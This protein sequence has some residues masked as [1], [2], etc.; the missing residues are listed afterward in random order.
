M[1]HYGWIFAVLPSYIKN[2]KMYVVTWYDWRWAIA[3]LPQSSLY[4][5]M[6]FPSTRLC[7][8]N[9]PGKWKCYCYNESS[10]KLASI[11]ASSAMTQIA[12]MQRAQICS[13]LI[14]NITLTTKSFLSTKPSLIWV[15]R[16][17]SVGG[18]N[19]ESQL[20]AC[21]YQ[22][23]S[24][25]YTPE[26]RLRSK[27]Q[28]ALATSRNSGNRVGISGKGLLASSRFSTTTHLVHCS[29]NLN[30]FEWLDNER[31]VGDGDGGGKW[32]GWWCR[33][34]FGDG[35]MVKGAT[36]MGKINGKNEYVK[37]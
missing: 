12:R 29:S 22:G 28:L 16:S 27:L 8:T 10:W 35:L 21:G 30:S 37:I 25:L 31:W 18:R 2:T 34:W 33:W 5:Y 20:K 6:K 4:L 15:S 36:A 1:S 14:A 17:S 23:T 7:I 19:R 26:A 3:Q 32:F 11:K 24:W 13:S 9:R